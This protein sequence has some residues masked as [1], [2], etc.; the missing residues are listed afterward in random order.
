MLSFGK[1]H[2]DV[3]RKSKMDAVMRLK[4]NVVMEPG[5]VAIKLSCGRPDRCYL[6]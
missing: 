2:A 1:R 3:V 5:N 4:V 6:V